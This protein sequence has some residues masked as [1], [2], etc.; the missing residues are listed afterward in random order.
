MKIKLA[1][2][3]MLLVWLTTY[4][5]SKDYDFSKFDFIIV[6]FDDFMFD[7]WTLINL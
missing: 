5:Q 2:L 4:S 3:T 6:K 7:L 1:G